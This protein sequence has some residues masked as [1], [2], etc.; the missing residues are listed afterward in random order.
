MLLDIWTFLWILVCLTILI[1][2]LESIYRRIKERQLRQ[3]EIDFQCQ[4]QAQQ[5]HVYTLQPLSNPSQITS[6]PT[7]NTVLTQQQQEY[8][9]EQQEL[10]AA[11]DLPPKYEDVVR[12]PYTGV[13]IEMIPPSSSLSQQPPQPSQPT[14]S[15]NNSDSVH[16][17]QT[18]Y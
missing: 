1:S 12:S 15:S 14:Q 3:Q 7:F 6:T 10:K 2:I 9:H 18:R 4:I 11:N 13:P 8:I 16:T 17:Q 5:Y